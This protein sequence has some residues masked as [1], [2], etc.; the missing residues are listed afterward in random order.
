MN[1]S[2]SPDHWSQRLSKAMATPSEGTSPVANQNNHTDGIN[3]PDSLPAAY[4]R[5]FQ[6]V[7]Q[8]LLTPGN[9]F[10]A[11]SF[12]HSLSFAI[13]GWVYAFKTQRNFRIDVFILAATVTMGCLFQVSWGAW[14]ALAFAM[15]LLLFAECANTAV[16]LLVDFWTHGEFDIRAKRIKDVMAGACLL[17]AATVGVVEL[18]VFAPKLLALAAA[19]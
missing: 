4:Q 5:T 6:K 1:A 11:S 17:M 18:L 19:G 15:G 8:H 2:P 9:R 12:W 16:E 3:I 13:E 7:D 14:L 10:Q